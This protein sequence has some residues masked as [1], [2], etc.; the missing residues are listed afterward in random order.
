MGCEECREGLSARLDGE[1]PGL[2]SGE[3]DRHLAQ[4][5][6]CRRWLREA[7]RLHRRVR[8]SPAEA[9]PDLSEAILGAASGAGARARPRRA[10]GRLVGWLARL[11]RQGPGWTRSSR[12]TPR[13][14]RAALV[15]VAALQVALVIPELVGRMH[16]THEA[17]SWNVAVA[18]GFLFVAFRPARAGGLVPVVASAV[19][20]LYAVTVRDVLDGEVHLERE[21]A[22]LGLLAGL[23]LLLLLRRIAGE[24]PGG[25]VHAHPLPGAE[26][27]PSGREAA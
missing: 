12:P 19:V 20:L 2:P 5:G 9:V 6:A 26:G 8:L 3:L 10:P 7:E 25:T 23:L 24:P 13:W 11:S 1:D 27:A 15:L 16:V 18:A 14:A 17:A 22:H 21:V 4:C